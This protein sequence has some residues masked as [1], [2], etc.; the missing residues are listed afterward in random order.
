M[1]FGEHVFLY[2][3]RGT[4]AAL[5]AEPINAISN[6]GFLLAALIFWQ[7]LLWRPREERSADQFLLVALTFLVGFGSLAFH[8]YA[9]KGTEL[10]DVVP[11]G[12]FMLVYLG[13]ALNRF[14]AVPPGWTVLLA[15]GFT[16]LVGAAMHV[17]CWE[18]GIGWPGTV[19]DAKPCLNG[20]V[21]YLPA[22]A[23]L[24]VVGMVLMERHHRAGPYIIWAAVIFTV[25]IVL[26]SLDL[27]FC[28]RVVIDGRM[29]GTH[30]IWHLLNAVVLFLLLRA[31]LE[32]G[33]VGAVPVKAAP[34]PEAAPVRPL[35]EAVPVKDG[36]KESPAVASAGQEAALKE[37]E[38]EPVLKPVVEA[39]EPEATT[40]PEA[41]APPEAMAE[42]E[43]KAEPEAEDE[44]KVEP[45]EE[46]EAAP[47]EAE[48]VEPPKKGRSKKKPPFPA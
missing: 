13:F 42:L 7:L 20:S 40:A 32:A 8:L 5:W 44:A 1:T 30:F 28:D 18:G 2:C 37:P 36:I 22:L 39:E 16:L 35:V 25:S 6:A 34:E 47:V 21:A 48:P 38:P 11:I 33:P 19:A 17:Y 24:I 31:T 26:R 9:D 46:P 12:L 23:A 10:A 45:K 27:S 3:E 43:A 29:V 15:V 41:K 14:L 4:N